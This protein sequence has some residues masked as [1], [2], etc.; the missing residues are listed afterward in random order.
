MRLL[1]A[2]SFI[3]TT[4]LAQYVAGHGIVTK[5]VV[6]STKT[7]AGY[8]ADFQYSSTP[9]PAVGWITP[10]NEETG[11]IAPDQYGSADIICHLN[12]KVANQAAEVN[13]GDEIAL[14]WT[15]WPKDHHGPVMDYLAPVSGDFAGVDKTALKFFKIDGVGLT[16]GTKVRLPSYANNGSD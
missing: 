2:S 10:D 11:F 12:A 6:A 7:Y 14:H 3:L 1:T 8:T 13:A 16:D 5:V 15:K 4:W 9:V